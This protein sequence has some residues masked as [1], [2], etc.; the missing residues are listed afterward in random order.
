MYV[1]SCICK[2]IQVKCK[3]AIIEDKDF[4]PAGNKLEMWTV[5]Y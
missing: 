5:K 3:Q 2:Q 1:F 4:F